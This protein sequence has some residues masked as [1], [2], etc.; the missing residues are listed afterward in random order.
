MPVRRHVSPLGGDAERGGR[1]TERAPSGRAE[2][3][4]MSDRAWRHPRLRI[5]RLTR[6][7][8][9]RRWDNKTWPVAKT[10]LK[11]ALEERKKIRRAGWMRASAH[12]D[13]PD[14]SI[15]ISRIGR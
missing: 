4:T 2:L 11:R 5:E 8:L 7:I 15:V 12:R 14:R 6:S 3:I 9:G 10:T 13:Q 1:S